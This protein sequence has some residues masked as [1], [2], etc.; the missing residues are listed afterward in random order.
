MFRTNISLNSEQHEMHPLIFCWNK[1]RKEQSFG[2]YREYYMALSVSHP[3]SAR[4][5][6]IISRAD[7]GCDTERGISYYVYHIHLYLNMRKSCSVLRTFSHVINIILRGMIK[8]LWYRYQSRQ[9]NTVVMFFQ[10]YI[11]KFPLFNTKYMINWFITFG[12]DIYRYWTSTNS[13]LK[14]NYVIGLWYIQ[15]TNA[16]AE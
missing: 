1:F 15:I 14:L 10:Y 2:I 8:G 5:T 11:C 6:N 16:T 12:T 7:T 4:D 3:V 13:R 9:T